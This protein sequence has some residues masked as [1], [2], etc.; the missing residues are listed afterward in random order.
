[1]K[2][3]DILQT[4]GRTPIVRINKLAPAGVNLF[5]KLESFNPMGSIKDR[6]ALA[7]IEAAERSGA[8]KPGQ[9]VIEATSGNTGIGLAMVCASK[10]Y[11]LVLVMAESFSV[12]RRRLMRFL[13]AQ[14]VLTPASQKGTGMLA[15]AM[16]LAETHGWFLTRQFENE[17]NAAAHSRTTAQEIL[18]DFENEPLDYWVSTFGTGGTVNGV[19]RVLKNKSP[20]TRIIVAEPDNVPILASGIPQA[21]RPDGTPSASHPAFRPHPIQGTSTDFI[22][23]LTEDAV[24]A[25]L[26]DEFAAVD[27]GEAMQMSRELAMREGIFVGISAGA[28]FAAA[29]AIARKAPMGS[30]ILAMLPDTGERYLSTPLFENVPI[31]MTE[32][33]VAISNSTPAC[34]FEASSPSPTPAPALSNSNRDVEAEQFIADVLRENKVVLFALQW[35]EFCWSVR[36]MFAALDITYRS[37]DLDSV[38]LQEGDWG[39][40]IRRALT[41]L[42]G[43]ETIPQIF[44]GGE[45]VGG[46]TETFDHWRSG[47]LQSLLTAHGMQFNGKE[48]DPYQLLPAWLHPRAA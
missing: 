27:G 18:A 44:V 25:G 40:R 34:R 29:L 7:V 3:S 43:M 5:V 36:R 38:E 19:A 28:A 8:L 17:A 1:M 42:T 47:R 26:I 11:P 37:V 15:K 41:A 30:T 10:G 35:C 46:C 20:G 12:E 4:I 33:E 32:S 13:G 14:V 9:T 22:P 24:S 21:R 23:K 16:E 45:L 6:M 2:Y 31:A 48:I 39:G